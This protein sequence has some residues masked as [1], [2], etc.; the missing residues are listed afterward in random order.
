MISTEAE[1]ERR[2]TEE[3]KLQ[4]INDHETKVCIPSLVIQ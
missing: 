1:N 4:R 2:K 3:K